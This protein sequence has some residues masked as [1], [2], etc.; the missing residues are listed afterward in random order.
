M[1]AR[2]EEDR[3][4][5]KKGEIQLALYDLQAVLPTP[6]GQTPAFYYK[7]RLK[8]FNFTVSISIHFYFTFHQQG[9]IN[10]FSFFLRITEIE[11]DTTFCMKEVFV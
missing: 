7:S 3:E 1:R 4:N 5:A 8:C 9:T 10:N 11:N 6:I 2:T